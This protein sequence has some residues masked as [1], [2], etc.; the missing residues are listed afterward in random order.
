M[1]EWNCKKKK[2]KKDSSEKRATSDTMITFHWNRVEL[3]YLQLTIGTCIWILFFFTPAFSQAS[4]RHQSI[5]QP[6]LD[7]NELAM[8]FGMFASW[9]GDGTEPTHHILLLA[10]WDEAFQQQILL[11]IDQ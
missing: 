5:N 7:D 2:K 10:G 6:Q 9:H 8:L 11:K 4:H 1:V 3:T